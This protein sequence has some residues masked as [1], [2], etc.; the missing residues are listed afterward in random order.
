MSQVIRFAESD[1]NDLYPKQQRNRK[2][3]E[4]KQKV[5]QTPKSSSWKSNRDTPTVIDG[6][7][8]W[9]HDIMNDERYTGL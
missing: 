3:H 1:I 7:V 4:E 8:R 2:A 5:T 9:E 6:Q